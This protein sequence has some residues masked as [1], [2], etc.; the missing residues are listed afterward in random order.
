MRRV[1][2]LLILVTLV[3]CNI[4][5][6]TKVV[7]HNTNIDSLALVNCLKV[8]FE[9]EGQNTTFAEQL[10]TINS[11]TVN[12]HD[13]I[14]GGKKLV[15]FLPKSVCILCCYEQIEL[16]NRYLSDYVKSRTIIVA[17]FKPNRDLFVFWKDQNIKV[18]FLYNSEFSFNPQSL[19]TNNTSFFLLDREMIIDL[20]FVPAKNYDDL[21]I[22]YLQTINS[23]FA[24]LDSTN[25]TSVF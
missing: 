1:I 16:L 20:L 2:I 17:N 13:Y 8:F 24:S 19:N 18:P 25:L 11:D 3:S 9:N 10:Y 7:E 23:R 21:T 15:L 4:K 14:D 12:L 5:D 6:Q 22:F